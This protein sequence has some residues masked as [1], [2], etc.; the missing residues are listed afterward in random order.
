VKT[1]TPMEDPSLKGIENYPATKP[2]AVPPPE[3]APP[4]PQR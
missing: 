4:P 1:D 2:A 3:P